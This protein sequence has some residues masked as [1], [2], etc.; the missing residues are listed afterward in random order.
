MEPCLAPFAGV[1]LQLATEPLTGWCGRLAK[2]SQTD[3]RQ[4]GTIRNAC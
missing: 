4:K 1:L 2:V 3:L